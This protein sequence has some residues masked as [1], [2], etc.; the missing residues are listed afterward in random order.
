M[1]TLKDALGTR[2]LL[3]RIVLPPPID[4]LLAA[5]NPVAPVPAG[6]D[7]RGTV[8]LGV[9][10]NLGVLAL[11]LTP[12]VVPIS[13]HLVADAAAGSSRL[14]LILSDTPPAKK[15]FSFAAGKERARGGGSEAAE[16]PAVTSRKEREVAAT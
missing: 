3:N 11:D 6:N 5:L 15:L 7:V 13:Y 16:A 10:K 1:A 9:N 4:E 2:G 8:T 12:P 14:W